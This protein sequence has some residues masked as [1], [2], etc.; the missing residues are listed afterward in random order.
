[1]ALGPSSVPMLVSV[2][3]LFSVL[4]FEFDVGDAVLV[5]G[6]G[7]VLGVDVVVMPGA[8]QHEVVQAGRS[9][10]TPMSDV[11]SFGPAG[12]FPAVGKN[13]PVIADD[14][15]G[16]DLFGMTLVRLPMSRGLPAGEVTTR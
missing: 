12:G 5:E 2:L 7:D 11:V 10:L 8:Q 13:A 4:V 3:V 15:R 14:Q 9:A 1:M 6:D 16:S